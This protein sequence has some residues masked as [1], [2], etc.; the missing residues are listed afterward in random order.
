MG[1]RIRN[2]PNK[3]IIE[4]FGSRRKI[5]Q[6]ISDRQSRHGKSVIVGDVGVGGEVV[7]AGGVEGTNG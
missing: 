7:E 4:S 6:P 5:F 2:L 3:K 1:H